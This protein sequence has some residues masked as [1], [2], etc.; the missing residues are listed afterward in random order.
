M[1]YEQATIQSNSQTLK[2]AVT[3]R[4][5]VG[6]IY[7]HAPLEIIMAHGLTP[8][9]VRARPGVAGAFEAS[10]QTFACSYTRNLFSQRAN[11][12][13]PASAALLFPSNT[14]DSLLNVGDIWRVRFPED[15]IFR[16]TYPAADQ[17]EPA[18]RYLAEELR[19]LSQSI[20][21]AFGRSFSEE[22]FRDAASLT[23]QF[24]SAA[25]FLYAARVI[26]PHVLQYSKLAALI[27]AF[28]LSPNR[29]SANEITNV[30]SQ[31]QRTLA[32]SRLLESAK[33]IQEQLI[34][35]HLTPVTLPRDAK[36]P[37]IAIAGGMIDPGAIVALFNAGGIPEDALIMD[38]FSFGFKT[39]FT[40]PC[41]T[42]RD[43]FDSVARSILASP[44]EPTQEGLGARLTFLRDVLTNL[45]IDGLVVCEQS[46]CDPDE[47]EAPSLEVE[48]TKSGVAVM[49]LPIDPELSDRAR[50]G[51]RLQSFLETISPRSGR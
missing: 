31:V 30:S 36:S 1:S 8:T 15:I 49:R 12:Q 33:K 3:E 4:L 50:L 14:C 44:L 9:L 32:R 21:A 11:D 6:Y 19:S 23:R 43:P 39:V 25:Q 34:K 16:L 10:L 28:L 2:P 40:P 22:E 35:R 24:R 18:V 7:P 41:E 45:A 47:F 26:R 13:L 48:A 37:R 20:E 51:V 17:G 5:T 42:G 29:K 46:F 38:L 27:H